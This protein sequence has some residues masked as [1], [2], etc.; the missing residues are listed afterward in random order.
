MSNTAALLKQFIDEQPVF[1][2]HQHHLPRE[3]QQ[4]LTLDL[5][6]KRSYVGWC[7]LPKGSSKEERQDWLQSIRLNAYFVWLEKG[8]KSTYGIDRITANNWDAVSATIN[9]R[10]QNTNFHLDVLKVKG[11]YIGF[12]EDSYWDPGSDIG[13]PDFI[14]P[15]YRIDMWMQGDRKSTRLNSSHV[16]ISYAVFCLKKK[17]T[18]AIP[19]TRSK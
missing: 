16:A 12:M 10:H 18:R 5:I 2:T 3:S 4:E 8:L 1:S 9:K 11:K 15:V 17:K 13:Y 6:F 7:S 19:A 14:T